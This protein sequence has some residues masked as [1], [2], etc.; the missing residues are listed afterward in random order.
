[1]ASSILSSTAGAAPAPAP[2]SNDAFLDSIVAAAW[3]E[4]NAMPSLRNGLPDPTEYAV[5]TIVDAFRVEIDRKTRVHTII[6]GAW[7][8]FH[9]FQCTGVTEA[10]V[11]RSMAE[12]L[13]SVRFPRPAT[14]VLFVRASMVESLRLGLREIARGTG[15]AAVDVCGVVVPQLH[16]ELPL[17][18]QRRNAAFADEI[19]RRTEEKKTWLHVGALIRSAYSTAATEADALRELANRMPLRWTFPPDFLVVHVRASLL[20]GVG[21]RLEELARGTGARGATVYGVAEPA[22]AQ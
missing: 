8:P 10:D 22:D 21:E 1:M 3:A 7:Q 13:Q 18:T 11:L 14:L 5:E 9:V 12:R 2:M 4:I 20:A 6:A 19:L 15:A 16:A 17:A